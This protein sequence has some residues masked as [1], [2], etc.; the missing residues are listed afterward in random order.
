M[1]ARITSARITKPV[2]SASWLSGPIL[3][4]LTIPLVLTVFLVL[5]ILLVLTVLTVLLV[6]YVILVEKFT[7]STF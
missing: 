3:L 7:I 4:V 6:R 1:S 5:T 2:R